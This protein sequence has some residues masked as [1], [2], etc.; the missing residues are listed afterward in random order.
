LSRGY[1]G[2]PVKH[3]HLVLRLEAPRHAP[4]NAAR[5]AD[6]SDRIAKHD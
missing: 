2:H 1:T 4:R 3:A 6:A 5:F